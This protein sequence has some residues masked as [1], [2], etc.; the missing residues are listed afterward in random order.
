MKRNSPNC[1]SHGNSKGDSP[2][3]GSGRPRLAGWGR[4]GENQAGLEHQLHLGPMLLGGC[5]RVFERPLE[6]ERG[7]ERE[8]KRSVMRSG[9]PRRPSQSLPARRPL[10]LSRACRRAHVSLRQL[11]FSTLAAAK[12]QQ[13]S[14]F[15]LFSCGSPR[16]TNKKVLGPCTALSSRWRGPCLRLHPLGATPG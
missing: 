14:C 1:S 8:E 13:V 4:G 16:K 5:G 2:E 15:R 7:R 6:T 12:E 11:N 10:L 3:C 9:D